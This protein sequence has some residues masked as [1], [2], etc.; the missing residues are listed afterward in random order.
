[1]PGFETRGKG[2]KIMKKVIL[3]GLLV[4]FFAGLLG[5]TALAGAPPSTGGPGGPTT[6]E[7]KKKFTLGFSGILTTGRVSTA[8]GPRTASD[9]QNYPYSIN[10]AGEE[11][12]F[13][14]SYGF[15]VVLE[16]K[17]N[18]SI[19]LFLDGNFYTYK[20]LV[21]EKGGYGNSGWVYEQ[22]GW[23]SPYIGPFEKDCYFYMDTTGFR[24]GTKYVFLPGQ[25]QLWVG[26]GAGIYHWIAT[27][28]TGDRTGKWG[29]DAGYTRRYYRSDGC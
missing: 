23:E 7:K 8:M 20:R 1:M 28:G 25:I 13:D 18:P 3:F 26:I 5:S 12:P 6:K 27:F 10:V 29:S 24:I 21:A 17:I 19:R 4:V 14:G 16:Y 15:G 11:G 22:S 2:V 9:A